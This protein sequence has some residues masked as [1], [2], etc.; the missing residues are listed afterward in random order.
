MKKTTEI[1]LA[2]LAMFAG[3]MIYVLWRPDSLVMFSWFNALGMRDTIANLRQMN[4]PYPALF[5]DW[6]IYALPQ[7]LWFFSGLLG[8][9][10]IW[11]TRSK[12]N[13]WLY[14]SVF[15]TIALAT[16]IGQSLNIVP[17]HFDRYDLVLLIIA[18][19]VALAITSSIHAKETAANVPT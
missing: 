17:G 16:E 13:Y 4:S 15:F 14:F 3:G 11:R 7:A 12:R 6:V 2:V 5:S 18:G 1:I 19:L 8:F 9:H 10:C